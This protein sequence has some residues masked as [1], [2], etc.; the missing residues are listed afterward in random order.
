MN[1]RTA[2]LLGKVFGMLPAVAEQ[3][4]AALGPRQRQVAELLAAGHDVS[5]IAR[6]LHISPDCV[7][8][9][10]N[11]ARQKLGARNLA[12]LTRAVLLVQLVRAL[13]GNPEPSLPATPPEQPS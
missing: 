12:D 11:T 1:D 2:E 6:A 9:T 5:A 13:T 10:A 7:R 3:R 8:A 4:L